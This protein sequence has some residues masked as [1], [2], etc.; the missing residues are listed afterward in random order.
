MSPGRG[1]APEPTGPVTSAPAPAHAPVSRSALEYVVPLKWAS[2]T[3]PTEMT[4]YLHE[5][6]RTV[7]VTVVDGS[8]PAVWWRHHAL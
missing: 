8:E 2:G 5:L 1:G 4:A 3:D 7:D 6:S